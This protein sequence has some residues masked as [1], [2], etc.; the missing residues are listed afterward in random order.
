VRVE[1][2]MDVVRAAV[3][4]VLEYYQN[5]DVLALNVTVSVAGGP[6]TQLRNT[7]FVDNALTGAYFWDFSA[8]VTA[9]PTDLGARVPNAIL[10][11]S[12]IGFAPTYNAVPMI[13][14]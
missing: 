4:F 3:R 11:E 1:I 2:L 12:Q 6:F 10:A 8:Y 7:S 13:V 14:C 5:W 9:F